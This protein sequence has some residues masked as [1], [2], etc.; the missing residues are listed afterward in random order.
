MGFDCSGLTGYVLLQSGFR[1][2]DYSYAQRHAGTDVPWAQGRPGDI[3][4]YNGHVAVYLG[5]IDGTPYLLEAPTVG[6]YVQ[7]RPV[8]FSNGGVPVDQMLHRYWS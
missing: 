2:P 5:V 1:I 6:M 7:I 4:G 8:Y 3:I